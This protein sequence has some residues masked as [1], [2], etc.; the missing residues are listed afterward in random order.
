VIRLTTTLAALVLLAAAPSASAQGFREPEVRAALE[1][2]ALGALADTI[3][4]AARP[5]AILDRMLLPREPQEL[6]TTRLGGRPDLPA[7]TTWPRCHGYAQTFL[8]Q[9]RPQDL[10]AEL[11]EVGAHSGT[12]LFF[13]H[14][15]RAA[16]SWNQP[17]NGECATVVHA[18]PGTPLRRASFP[19]HALRLRP[20]VPRYDVRPDLPDRDWSDRLIAPLQAVK[21]DFFAWNDVE[22][23]LEGA[24]Y[25]PHRL[26]GYSASPVGGTP[27]SLRAERTTDTWRHLFTLGYDKP[28]GFAIESFG[29]VEFL[30]SPADLQAGRFECAC[31]FF[32]R[33]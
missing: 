3:A 9:L 25:R 6:G 21:V 1:A 10:P 5:A 11:A 32:D 26:L 19:R 23:L 27:C 29:R 28:L 30:I 4:P 22:D 2:R 20:A 33:Y 31:G 17:F 7:G 13:A 16:G 14:I 12:I 18:R 15:E 24:Q 8:A